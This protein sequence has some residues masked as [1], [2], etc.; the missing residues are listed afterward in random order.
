[1]LGHEEI[2]QD[3]TKVIEVE[4]MKRFEHEINRLLGEGK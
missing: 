2:L 4:T 3:L 1:M